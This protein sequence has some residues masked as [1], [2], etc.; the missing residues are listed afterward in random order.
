VKY[1]YCF[2]SIT[3]EPETPKAHPKY[4][5][6]CIAAKFPIKTSAKYYHLMVWAR[7][8]GPRWPESPPLVTSIRKNPL[9]TTKKFLFGLEEIF[10]RTR[11]LEKK[12]FYSD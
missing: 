5:K 9:P 1:F 6:T 11:R 12:N 3:F 10:I 2:R 4:R 8:S 7:C